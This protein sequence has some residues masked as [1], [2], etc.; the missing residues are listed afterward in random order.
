MTDYRWLAVRCCC[1]PRRIFGFLRVPAEHARPGTFSLEPGPRA[2][3]VT[4][5]EYRDAVQFCTRTGEPLGAPVAMGDRG[6]ELAVY[7]DDRPMVFWRGVPGF[8]ELETWIDRPGETGRTWRGRPLASLSRAELI[9]ALELIERRISPDD[10][11]P[12]EAQLMP[13]KP[14]PTTT[15]SGGKTT[16]AVISH[17]PLTAEAADLLRARWI[18]LSR[19][20]EAAARA[21]GRLDLGLILCAFYRH[22]WLEYQPLEPPGEPE[23]SPRPPAVSERR[24]WRCGRGEVLR[25]GRW[26]R[27]ATPFLRAAMEP[28]EFPP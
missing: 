19:G 18:A 10:R 2:A 27:G 20:P 23:A 3:Q 28:M 21:P 1:T 12:R 5:K 22:E 8:V 26:R 6:G 16:G 7:S 15:G 4:V 14:P 13:R 11:A 25:F 24:C 17:K 9:D